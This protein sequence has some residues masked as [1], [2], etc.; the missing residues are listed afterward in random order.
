LLLLTRVADLPIDR[1]NAAAGGVKAACLV[2]VDPG[3]GSA[4]FVSCGNQAIKAIDR[5]AEVVLRVTGVVDRVHGGR[6][7][8]P[9][10]GVGISKTEAA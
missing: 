2:A 6:A 3:R 1:W 5:R 4:R 10:Q 7:W 8:E 9:E